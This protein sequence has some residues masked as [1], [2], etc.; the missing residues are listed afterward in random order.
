MLKNEK[1]SKTLNSALQPQP[2]VSPETPGSQGQV[3]FSPFP[4]YHPTTHTGKE[5]SSNPICAE[6]IWA[7]SRK[8][9][10]KRAQSSQRSERLQ[11]VVRCNCCEAVVFVSWQLLN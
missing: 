2:V 8:N 9:E 3:P 7:F 5:L 4:L 1:L 11:R 6:V 10:R